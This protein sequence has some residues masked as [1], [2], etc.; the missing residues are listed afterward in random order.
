[1]YFLI[2]CLLC[3]RWFTTICRREK[4]EWVKVLCLWGPYSFAGNRDGMDTMS[5]KHKI[6]G[7]EETFKFG[8]KGDKP[9]YVGKIREGLF[10]GWYLNWVWGID[11]I[12]HVLGKAFQAAGTPWLMPRENRVGNTQNSVQLDLCKV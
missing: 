8:I 4:D 7:T 2:E 3:S 12:P 1:M 10:E 9:H 5:K 11:L 6:L